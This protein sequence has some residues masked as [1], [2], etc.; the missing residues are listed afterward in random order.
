MDDDEMKIY[1]IVL[2]HQQ[3][4]RIITIKSNFYCWFVDAR[5]WWFQIRFSSWIAVE[6]KYV[7]ENIDTKLKFFKI[8]FRI[9]CILYL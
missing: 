1:T 8:V 6:T 2:H 9:A 5:N 4:F 7:L 3:L